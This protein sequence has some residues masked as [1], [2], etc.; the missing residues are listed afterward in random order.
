MSV[1]EAAIGPDLSRLSGS[2]R[3]RILIAQTQGAQW[4]RR[5]DTRPCFTGWVLETADSS[6]RYTL[7]D[8]YDPEDPDVDYGL[9]DYFEDPAAWGPV[10]EKEMARSET[11]EFDDEVQ[12]RCWWCSGDG[13]TLTPGPWL[14]SLP[15]AVAWG[16]LTKHGVLLES[17][18]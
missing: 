17:Q 5:T 15:E 3:T 10:L 1:T 8:G 16:T 9:P 4:R 13:V 12:H 18:T 11:G 7:F 6:L 2:I 14:P